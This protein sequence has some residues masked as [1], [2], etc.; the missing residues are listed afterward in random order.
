M[1]GF[2]PGGE[3]R[4]D[5]TGK[6][7]LDGLRFAVKDLIDVAGTRTGAGNPDWLARAVPAERHAPAVARLLQA[8]AHC[9]GKTITD[10]LAF[11]LEGENLH[12]GT[13]VNPRH[14]D[15]LPGGSS[16]GS[17]VAVAAGAVDFALG[18]DTGG[19]VRVPAA[20][21]GIFGFRPSHGAISLA[22]V[23]PFAPSY[24]TIGWFARDAA[25]L[26][27]VGRVLLPPAAPPPITRIR[28]ARDVLAEMDPEIA[29]DITD[30]AAR[31]VTDGPVDLLGGHPLAAF[32][33]A[34]ALVQGY[35]IKQALGARLASVSPRFAPPIA[36]RFAGALAIAEADYQSAS[37]D[38][39]R[40]ARIVA[41]CCPPDTAIA[42]PVVSRRH[43]RRDASAAERGAFYAGTLGLTA[44]AGHAGMPQVQLGATRGEGLGLALL[45]S[46]GC[47]LALLDLARRV[48]E[49]DT[50]IP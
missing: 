10:E 4:L 20:F 19:S 18:T 45:G 6:G 2:L 12:F 48:A 16:S 3:G 29:G 24:D 11:S 17:A 30:A 27:R 46:A 22:G 39:R 23:L 49:T 9:L 15:W 42:V 35:E 28:L 44:L 32:R 25:V 26:E 43:V 31:L 14:P 21:C 33:Q 7:P 50:D 38:R 13:P 5:P 8:G 36:E 1:N 37:A 47:D 41:S 40:L 34:Y